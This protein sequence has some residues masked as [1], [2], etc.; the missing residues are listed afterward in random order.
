ML[1]YLIPLFFLVLLVYSEINRKFQN[2]LS[3]R[4]FYLSIFFIFLIFIGFRDKIGCDWDTYE[5]NFK[6]IV[7][8]PFIDILSNQSNFFNIGYIFITKIVSLKFEFHINIL[9]ISSIFTGSLFYFCSQ[10]KRTYLSLMISYPYYFLIIGM[11]PI[12]QSLAISFLMLALIFIYLNNYRGY[13]LSTIISSSFHHSAIFINTF[14][15]TFLS[16][17]NRNK[18]NKITILSFYLFIFILFI[19]S[20]DLILEKIFSYLNEY[21]NKINPSK[22]AIFVWILNFFPSIVFLTNLSKFKFNAN[23]KRFLVYFSVFEICLLPLLYF[24][25]TITYRLLLYSFPTSIFITSHIPDINLFR[26]N[27]KNVYNFLIMMSFSSLIIWMKY[28]YHAYC[29]L[30]YNNILF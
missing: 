5:R 21:G 14:Y 29:W 18:Q 23:I 7:N 19:F 2:I 25:S 16:F 17:F 27:E 20:K 3:S 15:F 26:V 13:F 1:I 24:N 30:P 10:L 12:R 11:G 6:D 8:I 28:A 22:G 4:I 9:V